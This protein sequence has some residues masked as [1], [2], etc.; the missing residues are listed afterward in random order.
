MLCPVGSDKAPNKIKAGV[1]N[2]QV[3]PTP[4]RQ[5]PLPAFNTPAGPTP[6]TY[7]LLLISPYQDLLNQV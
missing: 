5:P 6:K 3:E 2:D 4:D 7:L 1:T